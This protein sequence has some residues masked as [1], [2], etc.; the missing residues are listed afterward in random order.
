[1]ADN[2]GK[3]QEKHV[4]EGWKERARKEK[5]S[6]ESSAASEPA[7]EEPASAGGQTESRSGQS[8][9]TGE[10]PPPTFL[11]LIAGIAAQASVY[12]G[13]MENPVTGKKEKDIAAARHVVDT[14]AMLQ[15]KTQGNLDDAE[16]RYLE[17]LLYGLR[18]E[19]VKNK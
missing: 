16:S 4:D 15:E 12:L 18:M 1:M 17:E 6:L 11:G 3:S 9:E 10:I 5:E 14:L 2:D 13:L 7:A 19:F 8:A